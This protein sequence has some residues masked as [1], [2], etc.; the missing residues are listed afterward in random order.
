M[1]PNS[2]NPWL[3]LMGREQLLRLT[4]GVRVLSVAFPV[5]PL[6]AVVV[7]QMVPLN[8]RRRLRPQRVHLPFQTLSADHR[9]GKVTLATAI[10][11]WPTQFRG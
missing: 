1:H 9:E 2:M 4:H 11:F 7:H 3:S 6:P 10:R 5:G 8:R